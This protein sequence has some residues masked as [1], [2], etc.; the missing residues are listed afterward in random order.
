MI[1]SESSKTEAK[2]EVLCVNDLSLFEQDGMNFC[3]E[4]RI[5]LRSKGS[6]RRNSL[7]M[8]LCVSS[9]KPV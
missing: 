4:W 9:R 8:L 2:S 7:A 6:R 1:V 3:S 5:G